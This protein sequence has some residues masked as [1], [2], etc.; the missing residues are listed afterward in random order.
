MNSLVLVLLLSFS[1]SAA[2][3]E[4][5]VASISVDQSDQA[6]PKESTTPLNDPVSP[7]SQ[8]SQIVKNVE[9]ATSVPSYSSFQNVAFGV[10]FF[11]VLVF[12]IIGFW[13]T[14]RRI[15][16]KEKQVVDYLFDITKPIMGVASLDRTT[17]LGETIRQFN[18]DIAAL[19]SD[20]ARTSELDRFLARLQAKKENRTVMYMTSLQQAY[21]VVRSLT[22]CYP[23]IGVLG[24]IVGLAFAI[25]QI[26]ITS[27]LDSSEISK[28]LIANFTTASWTTIVGLILWP[29]WT[30]F[31]AWHDPRVEASTEALTEAW[32]LVGEAE[33]RIRIQHSDETLQ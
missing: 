26:N 6:P 32:S 25:G 27:S 7:G 29:F 14:D 28:S 11:M 1:Q 2:Q 24:T 23:V 8:A 5:A 15:R 33:R 16:A 22:E 17:E 13:V 12:Q 18:R 31:F 20:P 9:E 19:L 30:I 10:G 21:G 4:K 3:P